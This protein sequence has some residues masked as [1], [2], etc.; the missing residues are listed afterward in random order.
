MRF[1]L[2]VRGALLALVAL[3]AAA[4]GGDAGQERPLRVFAA[5]SLIDVMSDIEREWVAGGGDPVSFNFAATSQ[6]AMQIRQGA[7]ADVFVSA[8][9]AWMDEIDAAGLLQAGT[10]RVVARNSLVLVTSA[11]SELNL[12]DDGFGGL[13]VALG[14]GR[15]AMADPAV[16]A[17]RYARSALDALGVWSALSSQVVYAPDVRAVLRLVELGEA[18]AGIVYRTDAITGRV[19]TVAEF[20]ADSHPPVRY[21]AA[22]LKD[23]RGAG[24]VAFLSESPA[25]REF[26]AHGFA[27]D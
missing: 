21:P 4:C 18:R 5:A 22:A 16:P 11:G 19:V 12:D 24:F 1:E 17:G 3:V 27:L 7:E 2:G 20:P 8:D 13:A 15:L 23:G 14:D 26:A 10:R 25:Q 9:E 6:L